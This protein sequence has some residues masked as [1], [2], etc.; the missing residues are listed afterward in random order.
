MAGVRWCWDEAGEASERD[1]SRGGKN[2]GVGFPFGGEKEAQE[3][4]PWLRASFNCIEE[5]GVFTEGCC[6]QGTSSTESGY[7]G[8]GGNGDDGERKVWG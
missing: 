2:N 7:G 1:N 6:V 3:T 8:I 4:L 5:S